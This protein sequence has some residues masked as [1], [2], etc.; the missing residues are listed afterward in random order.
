LGVGTITIPV[1]FGDPSGSVSP[2]QIAPLGGAAGAS[3]G[4]VR[5]SAS[6]IP[7]EM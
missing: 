2:Q 1:S 4:T 7:P 3:A 5:A 6:V